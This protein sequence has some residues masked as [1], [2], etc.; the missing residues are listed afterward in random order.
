MENDALGAVGPLTAPQQVPPF[1]LSWINKTQAKHQSSCL[2]SE[3][4]FSQFITSPKGFDGFDQGWIRPIQKCAGSVVALGPVE[5]AGP[6][7]K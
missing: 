3:A 5:R 1:C 2:H 6:P 4:V 7:T